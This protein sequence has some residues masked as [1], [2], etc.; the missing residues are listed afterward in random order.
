MTAKLHEDKWRFIKVELALNRE[1]LPKV[2]LYIKYT[3]ARK[4]NLVSL[5]SDL[6]LVALIGRGDSASTAGICSFFRSA[7][8]D[9]ETG[10]EQEGAPLLTSSRV[11]FTIA[12]D[13]D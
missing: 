5:L 2:I 13:W 11:F 6:N 1:T 10:S 8:S 3:R 12:G 4:C 7:R 9:W